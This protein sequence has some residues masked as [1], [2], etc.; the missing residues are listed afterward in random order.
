MNV[1]IRCLDYQPIHFWHILCA[2]LTFGARIVLDSTYLWSVQKKG[3]FSRKHE[4]QQIMVFNCIGIIFSD[5][6]SRTNELVMGKFQTC[7]TWEPSSIDHEYSHDDLTN[8]C[9]ALVYWIRPGT[10]KNKMMSLFVFYICTPISAVHCDWS[11][12][13]YLSA[14]DLVHDTIGLVSSCSVYVSGHV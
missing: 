7:N 4:T 6:C 2:K 9:L 1:H 10:H 12:Y 11:A 5:S 8:N 14:Y 13:N 3:S